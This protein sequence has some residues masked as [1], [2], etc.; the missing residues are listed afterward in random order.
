MPKIRRNRSK[1]PPEGWELMEPTL[2]E[3]EAKM[4]EA[5]CESHE[6]KRR[7]ESLW[8]IFKI[9]H[10]RS[11]YVYDLFYKRKAISRQLYEYCL[12]ER[13]ADAALIAKWK[14]QGFYHLLSLYFRDHP[15]ECISFK[16]SCLQIHYIQTMMLSNACH[17]NDDVI[18]CHP[19]E[20]VIECLPFRWWWFK[21]HAF[22]DI[23]SLNDC[24][25][26][27]D[28]FKYISFGWWCLWMHF[29]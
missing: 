28:V 14:K 11:R 8:S 21:W 6:G 17:L 13:I 5:E 22:E 26:N 29:V 27:E 18:E 24:Y 20:D 19:N 7:V 12:K 4:R 25:S 15:E 10:Q 9:H 16:S 2:E 1:P 3:L 23:M